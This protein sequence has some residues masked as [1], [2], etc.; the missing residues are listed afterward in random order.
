M[1]AI[2]GFHRE[3]DGN[4]ALLGHYAVNN[5]NLLLTFWA[6]YRPL[7]QRSKGQGK[8]P[9]CTGTEALYR[10]HGPKGE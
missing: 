6:I 9:P 7:H 2:S 4:C 8:V 1:F 5:G 10:L 3:V